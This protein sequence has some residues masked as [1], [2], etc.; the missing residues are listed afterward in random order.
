MCD[1]ETLTT[2][3]KF[4]SKTVSSGRLK[5]EVARVKIAPPL[6]LAPFSVNT[7][8]LEML[9]KRALAGGK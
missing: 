7:A 1:P 8:D 6:P 4:P 3:K 2:D 5:S 9:V